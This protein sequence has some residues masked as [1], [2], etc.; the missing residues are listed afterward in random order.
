MRD[1]PLQD[2]RVKLKENESPIWA[3]LPETSSE[4]WSITIE[5]NLKGGEVLS[6]KAV[7]Q[8]SY[9][10]PSKAVYPHFSMPP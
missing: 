3:L 6:A 2:M 5:T 10:I 4:P 1:C 9:D 8:D 7:L